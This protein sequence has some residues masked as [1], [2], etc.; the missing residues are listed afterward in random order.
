ML[1]YS[2]G[3]DSW[4][5]QFLFQGVMEM[6]FNLLLNCPGWSASQWLLGNNGAVLQVLST[7][8]SHRHTVLH[9]HG[10]GWLSQKG[11]PIATENVSGTTRARPDRERSAI[12][13][14]WVEKKAFLHRSPYRFDEQSRARQ[15]GYLRCQ[16]P[17]N[18]PENSTAISI[19]RNPPRSRPIRDLP[20]TEPSVFSYNHSTCSGK[21]LQ[22]LGCLPNVSNLDSDPL[23]WFTCNIVHKIN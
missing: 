20:Q 8:W 10:T 16:V 12:G 2:S 9:P 18:P 13:D 19:S 17:A 7:P 21:L 3:H 14:K 15:R 6:V 11:L 23:S 1:C 22:V 5:G 4:T